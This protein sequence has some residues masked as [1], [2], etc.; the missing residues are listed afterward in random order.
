MSRA[1]DKQF[2][3]TVAAS[4]ILDV[5]FLHCSLSQKISQSLDCQP[6]IASMLELLLSSC[7]AA[8]DGRTSCTMKRQA[9]CLLRS[10]SPVEF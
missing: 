5:F 1:G 8:S 9:G 10:L 7:S 3:L 6:A 2:C 4:S